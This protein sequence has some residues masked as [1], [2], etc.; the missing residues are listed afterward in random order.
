VPNREF[1]PLVVAHA[2]RTAA[3]SLLL[4]RA[5]R[6][7][8]CGLVTL[9]FV[10]VA[11]VSSSRAAPPTGDRIDDPP[12]GPA[13]RWPDGLRHLRVWVEPW[14]T[15]RGWTPAHL[16]MVDSALDA[17]G[18]AGTVSF[19]RVTRSEDADIRVRWT[20]RLP[21]SHPGV[22]SLTPNERGELQVA[23][24]WINVALP[25]TT[26]DPSSL[27]YGVVAHELGHALGLSHAKSRSSVMYPVLYELSVTAGDL[28]ALRNVG[29]VR[30][31]AWRIGHVP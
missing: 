3:R 8:P 23:S 4:N 28:E 19:V 16:L 13:Y 27:L 5:A 17:W 30:G 15:L 18:R 1:A 22:T 7:V 9:A 11:G 29:A 6:L 24:I 20:E 25:R 31:S 14:S 21:A 2:E 10:V 12:S 26:A